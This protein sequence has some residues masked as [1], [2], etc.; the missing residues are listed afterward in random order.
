MIL[1]LDLLQGGLEGVRK[2][3]PSK[4]IIN[5]FSTPRL[6]LSRNFRFD[7]SSKKKDEKEGNEERKRKMKKVSKVKMAN[8]QNIGSGQT[9]PG[10][11][12]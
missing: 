10:I 5:E 9:A 6:L 3:S 2:L 7:N 1:I 12:H 11:Y 8:R 4:K